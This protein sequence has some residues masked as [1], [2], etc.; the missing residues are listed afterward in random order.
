MSE[1]IVIEAEPREIIGKQTSRLRREG[2]IPGVIYGRETPKTVQ[3]EQ[4]ALRRALRVVGT[5]HL[6]DLSVGGATHTVLVREIQQHATRGDII[7]VDFMEVDMKSKLRA[8]AAI[9]GTGEAPPEADGLGVATILL[10]EVEIECLPEDLVAEIEFDL[11]L[12]A[13]P[14]DVVYVRDLVAPKGVEILADPDTVVASFEYTT[15]E[16]TEEEEGFIEGEE[17]AEDVEVISRGKK[18]E[19]DF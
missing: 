11:G 17:S 8:S 16:E 5:A 6:A 3:M 2:W 4:R 15:I 1:R 19:E 14:E 13:T 10:R 12:I 18:E 7:H 9:V